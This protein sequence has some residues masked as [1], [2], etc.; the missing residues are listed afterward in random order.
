MQTLHSPNSS[1]ICR[2]SVG[3]GG[4]LVVRLHAQ[5]AGVASQNIET[6]KAFGT[7]LSEETR[8]THKVS[9]MSAQCATDST[10]RIHVFYMAQSLAVPNCIC[11][12]RPGAIQLIQPK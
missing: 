8:E 12:T 6:D 5:L 7:L 11:F 2:G 4:V 3:F 9:A 10:A 1:C